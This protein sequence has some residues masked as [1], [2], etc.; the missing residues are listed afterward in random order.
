MLAKIQ[1]PKQPYDHITSVKDFI[2]REGE[3]LQIL[4]AA[5]RGPNSTLYLSL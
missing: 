1:L 3:M 2:K 5:I 4:H